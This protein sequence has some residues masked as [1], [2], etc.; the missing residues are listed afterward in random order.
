MNDKSPKVRNAAILALGE[1]KVDPAQVEPLFK[2]FAQ[3]KDP[4]LKLRLTITQA[5][6]GKPQM[7]AIPILIEGLRTNHKKTSQLAQGAL[8]QLAKTH[9]D[10]MLPQLTEIIKKSDGFVLTNALTLLRL[11][12]TAAAPALPD[13]IALYANKDP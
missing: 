3:D 12:K 9:P 11:M 10:K 8:R 13:I 4:E 6:L 7:D 5:L 2:K 1:I